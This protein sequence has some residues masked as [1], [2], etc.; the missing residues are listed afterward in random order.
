MQQL[1]FIYHYYI[2]IHLLIFVYKHAFL[3]VEERI[4]FIRIKRD[5]AEAS[6]SAFR[7]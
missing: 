2:N 3:F 4:H 1:L 5:S 6:R 7:R